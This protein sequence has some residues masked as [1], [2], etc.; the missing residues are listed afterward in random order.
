MKERGIFIFTF[1]ASSSPG[2]VESLPLRAFS[3]GHQPLL[4]SKSRPGRYINPLPL[5]SPL[6]GGSILF[7]KAFEIT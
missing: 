1:L 7:L 3:E 5:D 6:T 4:T 2:P